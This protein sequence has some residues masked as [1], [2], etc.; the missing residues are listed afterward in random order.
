M[1]FLISC[2]MSSVILC[3]MSGVCVMSS[4][5]LCMMSSVCLA[6]IFV[7]LVLVVL[8]KFNSNLYLAMEV[9]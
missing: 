5:I 1:P 4:V 3:M 6:E 2:V 8:H 9:Q 7:Y